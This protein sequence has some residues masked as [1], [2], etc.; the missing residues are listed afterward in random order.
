[1]KLKYH[2]LNEAGIATS[3]DMTGH[4]H[5]GEVD[6]N[7]DGET[8]EC[9]GCQVEHVHKIFQWLEVGKLTN[10]FIR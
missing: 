1:M 6:E 10:G 4:A 9:F 2:L 5:L 8:V 3:K 7:G